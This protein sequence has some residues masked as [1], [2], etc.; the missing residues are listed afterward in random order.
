L[1][2]VARAKAC[3]DEVVGAS[4][5]TPHGGASDETERSYDYADDGERMVAHRA[6]RRISAWYESDKAEESLTPAGGPNF[7]AA[8]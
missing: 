7:S 6:V 4:G 1:D 5:K 3:V 2:V 8:C